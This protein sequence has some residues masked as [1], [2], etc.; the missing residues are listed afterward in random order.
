MELKD[1]ITRRMSPLEQTAAVAGSNSTHE[2]QGLTEKEIYTELLSKQS[3]APN[4]YV[5]PSTFTTRSGAVNRR[6]KQ[7]KRGNV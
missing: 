2:G 6:I 4:P 5:D 3:S 7:R 1:A